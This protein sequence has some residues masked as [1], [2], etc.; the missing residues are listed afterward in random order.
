MT[1]DSRSQE[2]VFT[3]SFMA[4]EIPSLPE[5]LRTGFLIRR[6]QK[7]E[8]THPFEYIIWFS[9]KNKITSPGRGTKNQKRTE[10]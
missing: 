5:G 10:P 6:S 2:L 7:S 8:L 3:N 1:D 4:E 9:L